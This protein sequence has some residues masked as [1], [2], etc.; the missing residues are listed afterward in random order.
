[1]HG[2]F[3]HH[4]QHLNTTKILSVPKDKSTV[5]LNQESVVAKQ[6]AHLYQSSTQDNV[7]QSARGQ[8]TKMCRST[9][10]HEEY[11]WTGP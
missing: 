4:A 5:G 8:K 9:I 1:M 3:V 6:L 10:M 2:E 7:L 11:L